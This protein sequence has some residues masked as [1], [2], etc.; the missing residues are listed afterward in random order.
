MNTNM[1]KT[2]FNASKKSTKYVGN[3]MINIAIIITI[4]NKIINSGRSLTPLS[5]ELNTMNYPD[6]IGKISLIS[7][8]ALLN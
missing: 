2:I 6:R 4:N 7:S 8:T 3:G 1:A 5:R